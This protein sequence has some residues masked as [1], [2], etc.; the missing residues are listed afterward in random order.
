MIIYTTTKKKNN[1]KGNKGEQR[2]I[3]TDT[4]VQLFVPW[5]YRNIL[6]SYPERP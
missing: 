4:E 5:I 1:N 3:N 2:E 6:Q